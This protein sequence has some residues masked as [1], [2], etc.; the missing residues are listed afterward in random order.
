MQ[1]WKR[2]S[3]FP[4]KRYCLYLEAVCTGRLLLVCRRCSCIGMNGICYAD[5]FRGTSWNQTRVLFLQPVFVRVYLR[6]CVLVRVC[7][8]MSVLVFVCVCVSACAC[9]FVYACLRACVCAMGKERV[10]LRLYVRAL[11]AIHPSETE[12]SPSSI[13][14]AVGANNIQIQYISGPVARAGI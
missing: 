9:L 7:K 11:L 14:T 13:R 4:C 8:C 12:A 10:C 1:F 5:V 2:P 6:S 3:A